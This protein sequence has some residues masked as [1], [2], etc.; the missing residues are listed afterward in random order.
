MYSRQ[1]DRQMD[2]RMDSPGAAAGKWSLCFCSRVP[3]HSG[4]AAAEW[5]R[6]SGE[7]QFVKLSA[8][9]VRTFISSLFVK[10][11]YLCNCCLLTPL[12]LAPTLPPHP[13][14]ALTLPAHPPPA[15]TLPPRP[16]SS[17]HTPSSSPP[18][19]TLPA[20]PLPAPTPSPH[21]LLTP[22][23]LPHPLLTHQKELFELLL[24][25]LV[26]GGEHCCSQLVDGH[27]Y[28]VDV[29]G[30]ACGRQLA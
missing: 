23:Q 19:P 3:P 12:V 6:Q 2:R 27:S 22:L 29:V 1:A 16:P 8:G 25:V 11:R 15:Y 30:V 20:Y 5:M 13:P 17:S 18:A 24:D 28:A 21:S 14:P 10:P 4:Q 9:R 7:N 26:Q